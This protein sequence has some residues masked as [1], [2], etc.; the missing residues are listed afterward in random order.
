MKKKNPLSG[1]SEAQAA[2]DLFALDICTR[3]TYI[4]IGGNHPRRINN[5]FNLDFNYSWKGFSVEL[6]EKWSGAW[7]KS[8][9]NNPC[10]FKDAIT[11]DYLAALKEQGMDTKIGYLS[12]DIEP[13]NNTFAA[14]QRV[15]GQGIEFECITFEHDWYNFPETTFNEQATEFLKKHGYKVAVRD[16]FCKKSWLPYETWYVR[17]DIVFEE[18]DF[19]QW[20]L[21]KAQT[22]Q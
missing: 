9:R 13:P 5:T 11:F 16:V 4:E 12:C 3:K 10:Y 6:I 8:D 14:L 22:L 21:N 7:S 15:I 1:K 20:R 19:Q 2:Q 17:E 18:I